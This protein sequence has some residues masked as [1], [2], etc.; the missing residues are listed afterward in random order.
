MADK[1]HHADAGFV[2]W[3]LQNWHRLA[4]DGVLTFATCGLAASG[5]WHWTSTTFR[6]W[7]DGTLRRSATGRCM[8]RLRFWLSVCALLVVHLALD[9]FFGR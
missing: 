4:L 2:T 9:G 8:R 3:L 1:R 6:P 5:V 7:L